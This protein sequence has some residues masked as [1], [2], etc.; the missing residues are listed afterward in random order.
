MPLADSEIARAHDPLACGYYAIINLYK[1][2][3]LEPPTYAHMAAA[4]LDDLKRQ[5]LYI[6]RAAGHTVYGLTAF[7]QL[8]LLV[9]FNFPALCAVYALPK[10]TTAE[11]VFPEMLAGG[12]HLIVNYTWE[13]AD[14]SAMGHSVVAEGL[15]PEGLSV[16]DSA[17]G[18]RETLPF[19]AT[20]THEKQIGFHPV[21]L[22][23]FPGVTP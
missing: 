17:S 13:R 6:R 1:L 4:F 11:D 2:R 5:T 10:W 14:G 20:A 22:V 23:A 16:L 15:K 7:D 9:R 19:Q 8:G 18:A 3:G 21:F 12:C